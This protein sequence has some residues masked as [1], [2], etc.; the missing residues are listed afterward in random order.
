MSTSSSP[1]DSADHSNAQNFDFRRLNQHRG[2]HIAAAG[3][4]QSWFDND[5]GAV[6]PKREP[7]AEVK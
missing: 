2:L 3:A 6:E 4:E 7:P 5:S 1:I